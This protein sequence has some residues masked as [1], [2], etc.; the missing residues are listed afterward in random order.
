LESWPKGLIDR[1]GGVTD[2]EQWQGS[3]VQRFTLDW[4]TK[5]ELSVT[6]VYDAATRQLKLTAAI[7]AKEG[8]DGKLQVW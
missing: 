6:P 1:H 3:V 8:V 2:F 7:E 4:Q 5:V